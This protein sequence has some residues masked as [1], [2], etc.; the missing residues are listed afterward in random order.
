VSWVLE[1]LVAGARQKT[2]A[3]NL[4]IAASTAGK[5]SAINGG[6]VK[7]GPMASQMLIHGYR[8]SIFR[9]LTRGHAHYS[10]APPVSSEFLRK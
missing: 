6:P 4:K 8:C 1:R 9:K 5:I 2:N 10:H 3:R 7:T